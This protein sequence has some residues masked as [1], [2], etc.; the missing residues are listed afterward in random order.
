MLFRSAR[1]GKGGV[2]REAATHRQVL[3]GVALQAF[4]A[5]FVP[6]AATW[7]PVRGPSG[8]IEFFLHGRRGWPEDRPLPDDVLADTVTRAHEV[9]TPC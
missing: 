3:A 8:N 2:V 7:S 5:G 4:E 6:V 9:L 1:V